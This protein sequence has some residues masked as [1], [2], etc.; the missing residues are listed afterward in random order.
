[1]LK[2]HRSIRHPQTEV[3]MNHPVFGEIVWSSNRWEGR[4][5]IPFFSDFD[6]VAAT[7]FCKET[8]TIDTYAASDDRHKVGEFEVWIETPEEEKVRPSA[9]QEFAFTQ[10]VGN[11]SSVCTIVLGAIYDL[12]QSDCTVW[13]TGDNAYSRIAV[14][15]IDSPDGLKR[16]IRLAGF[17]VLHQSR[18]GCALIGFSFNCS[19]DVEHGL[20]GVVHG[21]RLIEIADNAITWDGPYNDW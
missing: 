11:Q 20:G 17:H 18:D 19:W 5:R 12:Y 21:S 14:P 13:R 3:V 8:G 4:V 10:F 7:E 1:M 2:S 16:L 6:T 9:S 15:S